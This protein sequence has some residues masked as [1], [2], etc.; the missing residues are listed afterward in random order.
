MERRDPLGRPDAVPALG[1]PQ[2]SPDAHMGTMCARPRGSRR[3]LQ[4][5]WAGSAVQAERSGPGPA[6]LT[7]SGRRRD[8]R[9][10]PLLRSHVGARAS[11]GLRRQPLRGSSRPGRAPPERRGPRG[12]SSMIACHQRG[13]RR[14][15]RNETERAARDGEECGPCLRR[16]LSCVSSEDWE[17]RTRS[18]E[19]KERRDPLGRALMVPM[20]ASG[21]RR[22]TP[23]AGT[24]SG[25]PRESRRSKPAGPSAQAGSGPARISHQIGSEARSL[26]PTHVWKTRSGRG[27]RRGF[28]NNPFEDRC[29]QGA[30][31]RRRGTRGG[32]HRIACHQRGRRRSGRNEPNGRPEMV[33]NAGPACAVRSAR[34]GAGNMERRILSA[35]PTRS[36]MG[37]PPRSPDALMGTMC[38]RPRESRRSKPGCGHLRRAGSGVSVLSPKVRRHWTLAERAAATQISQEKMIER[39]RGSQRPQS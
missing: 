6:F 4:T 7:R 15:G 39:P 12:G 17:P 23:N 26:L 28:E 16:S 34:S 37:I 9:L 14:S 10:Q 1:V 22:G 38:A 30:R 29:V 24:A 18:A 25:R 35:D 21:L 36:R 5:S 2:R 8:R 13:R 3:S 31:R 20:S 32:S 27:H 33:R 19:D 11:A